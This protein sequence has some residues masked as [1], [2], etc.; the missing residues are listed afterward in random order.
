MLPCKS[1]RAPMIKI[2]LLKNSSISAGNCTIDND[3]LHDP[4]Q[5]EKMCRIT[6]PLTA[7]L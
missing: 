1:I 4:R 3:F 2:H 7:P 6:I 5:F